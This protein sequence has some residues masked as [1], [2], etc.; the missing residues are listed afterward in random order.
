M[1]HT[2]TVSARLHKRIKLMWNT[3]TRW[4]I[5]QS[6]SVT[7]RWWRG[8]TASRSCF[9]SSSYHSS[10]W[11]RHRQNNKNPNWPRSL[12]QHLCCTLELLQS[13]YRPHGTFLKSTR[14]L[15]Y[16]R[17]RSCSVTLRPGP[18]HSGPDFPQVFLVQIRADSYLHMIS[19]VSRTRHISGFL[20]WPS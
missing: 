20:S 6:V 2:H 13:D 5:V 3:F 11:H 18:P 4:A 9:H 16:L 10:D 17:T 1:F 14:T 12:Q 19:C 15:I 8:L 7:C